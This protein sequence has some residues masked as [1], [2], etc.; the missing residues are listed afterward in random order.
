M[1]ICYQ[2]SLDHTLY[3][4]VVLGAFAYKF[5]FGFSADKEHTVIVYMVYWS[6][7]LALYDSVCSRGLMQ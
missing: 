3:R 7:L 1:D 5:L 6:L 2:L 4:L